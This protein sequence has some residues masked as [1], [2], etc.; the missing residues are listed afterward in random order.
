MSFFRGSHKFILQLK[1]DD[2][3]PQEEQ[4]IK[5]LTNLGLTYREA[6]IYL[7]LNRIGKAT[8]KELSAAAHMDRPNVYGVI[9]KLQKLNL[10]E[11]MLTTPIVYK[12]VPMDQ[13]VGMMLD[14]KK[15][16]LTELS[17]ETKKLLKTYKN[18]RMYQLQE[19]CKLKIIPKE[20]PTQKKFDELFSGTEKLNEAVCYW[21]D[22]SSILS[23]DYPIWKKLLKKNVEVHLIVYIPANKKL[24][25]KAQELTKNPLF[26]IRYIESPPKI[27]LSIYDQKKAFLSTSL[28]P[29]ESSFL[30]VD[31]IDFVAFFQDYFEMLW[32]KSSDRY[33]IFS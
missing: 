27:S 25:E 9:A 10:I 5:I 3:L 23:W 24:P 17:I 12:S 19:G 2:M 28:S 20:T 8:V 14:H 18:I 4:P 33:P 29:S 32:Q 1:M 26:K 11:Q 31:N 15:H 30:L 22:P 13:G 16:E 21:P 7:T 6:K